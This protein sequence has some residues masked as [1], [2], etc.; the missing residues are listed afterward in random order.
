MGIILVSITMYLLRI[1][2][3]SRLLMGIFLV[4]NVSLLTL[5]KFIIFKI[6]EKVRTD[7]LNTKNILIVGSK[8]RARQVIE[9]VKTQSY[10]IYGS[11]L[12]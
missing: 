7:G 8:E 9:V 6:L 5:S 10:R 12:F 1:Q 3:V 11:G 4:L 2:G